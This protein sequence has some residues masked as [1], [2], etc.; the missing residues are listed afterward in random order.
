MR[1]HKWREFA[2]IVGCP[3]REKFLTNGYGYFRIDNK[4]LYSYEYKEY[5]TTANYSGD[6]LEMFLH[7]EIKLL[8][9]EEE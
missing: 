8:E 2:K 7:G 1:K 3:Y 5:C 6:A 9:N 4:G